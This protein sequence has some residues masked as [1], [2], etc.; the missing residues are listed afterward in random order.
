MTGGT[1]VILGA[2]GD[3]FGAGFTGGMA[4]LYDPADEFA[5]RAN[6]ESIDWQRIAHPHWE[7]VLRDLVET[8]VRET[9]SRYAAGLLHNWSDTVARIW[10]VV[11]KGYAKYLAAPLTLEEEERRA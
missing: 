9:N 10:Q 7:G 11:P 3:N 8:H 4:F 1:V 6:P 5:S 2:I